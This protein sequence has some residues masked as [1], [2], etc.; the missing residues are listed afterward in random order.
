[1]NFMHL[2]KLYHERHVNPSNPQDFEE[3]PVQAVFK[4]NG[5]IM[6]HTTI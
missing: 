2:K 1:M 6:K 3:I 5:F 4:S